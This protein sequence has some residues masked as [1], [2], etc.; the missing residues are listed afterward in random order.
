MF[1]QL[2]IVLEIPNVVMR[3][4]IE[5]IQA[6]INKTVHQVLEVS[7]GVAQVSLNWRGAACTFLLLLIHCC[8]GAAFYTGSRKRLKVVDKL[9]IIART[10]VNGYFQPASGSIWLCRK[11]L[12][13]GE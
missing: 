1:L 3:P 9:L 10:H 5:D 6:N 2:D 13:I 12:M 7:R 4:T 11:S 8:T